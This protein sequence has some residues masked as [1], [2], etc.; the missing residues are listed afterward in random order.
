MSFRK[1]LITACV[2]AAFAAPS[3]GAPNGSY[4]GGPGASS[5]KP[6]VQAFTSNGTWIKPAGAS[7]VKVFVYPGGTGAYNGFA[8]PNISICSGPSGA[9]GG[10]M[11]V[12]EGPASAISTPSVAVTVGAAGAS[13]ASPTQGGVSSFGTFL[14]GY[15]SGFPGGLGQ[16]GS[17]GVASVS[18]TGA[19]NMS[20]GNDFLANNSAG[21]L[22]QYT[23]S[24]GGACAATGTCVSAGAALFGG[25]GAGA[26]GG[27]ITGGVA[28]VGTTPRGNTGSFLLNL[29]TA[30]CANG[31][32]VPPPTGMEMGASG[33]G[34]GAC[35]TG[36]AGNG[37]DGAFPGGNAGPGGDGY[38][39]TTPGTAGNAAGGEVVVMTW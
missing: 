2:L 11:G 6:T 4:P 27:I 9:G 10:S 12:W 18:G 25:T 39:G 15:A 7:W 35:T 17:V 24:A 8:C 23:G 26:G 1:L 16:P 36:A 38:N 32:V 31:Q 19:G 13:G 21:A 3:Q 33:F 20:S 29:N 14:K 34:G 28:Q 5:Y 30:I 37:S 22:T